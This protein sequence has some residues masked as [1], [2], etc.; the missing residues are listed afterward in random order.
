MAWNVGEYKILSVYSDQSLGAVHS[1]LYEKE[2]KIIKVGTI[3]LISYMAMT[4][5][6]IAI[7]T[8]SLGALAVKVILLIYANLVNFTFV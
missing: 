5:K 7:L 2:E 8:I 6:I 3:I 4:C 1:F